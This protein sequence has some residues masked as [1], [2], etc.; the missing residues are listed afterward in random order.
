MP[1]MPFMGV[2]ISWLIVGQEFAFGLGCLFGPAPGRVQFL[3]QLGKPGGIFVLRLPGLFQI[4]CIALQF[5][6]GPFALGNVAGIRINHFLLGQRNR[7]PQEPLVG[8]VFA[9]IAILKRNRFSAGRKLRGLRDA[10]IAR[11]SGW[12]NSE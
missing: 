8:A 11:S 10:S 12:M 5:L 7:I 6:F 3:H 9:A 1:M 4:E 2:R